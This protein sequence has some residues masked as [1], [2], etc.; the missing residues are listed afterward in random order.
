MN[1]QLCI[2]LIL[3]IKEYH[4]LIG[5]HL[6]DGILLSSILHSKFHCSDFMAFAFTVQGKY[7]KLENCKLQQK[8]WY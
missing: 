6:F 8:H 1:N 4:V 3:F 2:F 7:K 5:I